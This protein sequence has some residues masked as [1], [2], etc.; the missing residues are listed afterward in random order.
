MQKSL[1]SQ[2][3]LGRQYSKEWPMRKELAPLFPE[4]RVIKATELALNT[5]PMLAVFTLFL[6]TTHLGWQYLPQAIAIAL[7]FLS[8]PVQGLLWLGKRAETPLSPALY[9]WYT[10]LHQ[11]MV[12]QGYDTPLSSRK[13]RYR[14]LARLLKDMFDKMDKAFTKENL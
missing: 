1:I 14:E 12:A 9:S 2:V 8:L 6:Q 13:P 3:Q 4:F 7:F 10:E 11:K 5:M